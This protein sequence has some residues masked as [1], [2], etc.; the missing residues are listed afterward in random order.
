MLPEL[1]IGEYCFVE[2]HGAYTVAS[3]FNGLGDITYVYIL[4]Y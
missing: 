4:K 1:A 3:Q 2:N